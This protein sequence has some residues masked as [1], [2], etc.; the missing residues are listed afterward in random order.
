MFMDIHGYPSNIDGFAQF[1]YAL[2]WDGVHL[3]SGSKISRAPSVRPLFCVSIKKAY[4]FAVIPSFV[5]L[6]AISFFSGCNTFVVLIFI[7][8]SA[9]NLPVLF[10]LNGI[11]YISFFA[12]FSTVPFN[13]VPSHVSIPAFIKAI[14]AKYLTV[15]TRSLSLSFRLQ[16]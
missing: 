8:L 1:S 7:G 11:W 16:F 15:S 4:L 3:R 10:L 13:A 14:T 6:D 9:R 2:V 5:D 12:F